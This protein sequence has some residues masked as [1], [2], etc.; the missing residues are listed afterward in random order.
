MRVG[1]GSSCKTEPK[2][3]QHGHGGGQACAHQC[4]GRGW[5]A[6]RGSGGRGGRRRTFP[7]IFTAFL[8]DYCGKRTRPSVS[9]WWFP[10]G[11]DDGVRTPRRPAAPQHRLGR[12]LGAAAVVTGVTVRAWPGTSVLPTRR[13]GR[14][15]SACWARWPDYCI[16]D[17]EP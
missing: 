12:G 11:E 14:C 16:S 4:R 5:G 13:L 6:G 3:A 2:R 1:N 9:S 10:L 15:C 8:R 7:V 17:V